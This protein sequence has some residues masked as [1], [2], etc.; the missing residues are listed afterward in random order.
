M[1]F[2]PSFLSRFVKFLEIDLVVCT[3][4]HLE[5]LVRNRLP[6][7]PARVLDLS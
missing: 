4:L 5:S 2:S 3:N 6:F 1:E 7:D